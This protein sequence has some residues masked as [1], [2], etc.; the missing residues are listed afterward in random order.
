MRNLYRPNLYDAPCD[1]CGAIVKSGQ[2]VLLSK[3][4]KDINFERSKTPVWVVQCKRN[5]HKYGD[6][7]TIERE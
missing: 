1:V 3:K 4:G 6:L 5:K 2:G 7:Y